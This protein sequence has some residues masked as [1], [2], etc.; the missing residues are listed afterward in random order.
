M[1]GTDAVIKNILDKMSLLSM[2]TIILCLNMWFVLICVL[3]VFT[4]IIRPIYMYNQPPEAVSSVREDTHLHSQ[5]NTW[6]SILRV[7]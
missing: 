2:E 1:R 6:A 4:S 7:F 5:H 3:V